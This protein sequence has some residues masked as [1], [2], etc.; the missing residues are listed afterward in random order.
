LQKEHSHHEKSGGHAHLPDLEL[1]T[2][3]FQYLPKMAF[4]ESASESSDLVVGKV[5]MPPLFDA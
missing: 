2:V 4:T 3:A 5:G 1:I